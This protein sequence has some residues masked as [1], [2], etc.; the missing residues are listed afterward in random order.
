MHIPDGYLSPQTCLA[1]WGVMLPIWAKAANKVKQTL[2]VEQVPLLSMGAAFSFI[3]MMFNVPIPDGTTGH[4]VGGTL[5]A[6]ILGPWA[7]V[8][9]ISVALIMQALL[10]GDGGVL[11]IGANCFNIGVAL[12]FVGYY[13]YK[14]ISGNA[15]AGSTRQVVAAGVAAYIAINVAGLLTGLELG[16]QPLLFK[17]ADGT[18][19]YNPYSL[20][21]ALPAMALAHFTIAGM[22]EAIVTASVFMCLHKTEPGLLA[23]YSTSS[24]SKG[25]S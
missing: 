17:A 20:Y 23:L 1:M 11:A 14:L 8:I 5:L 21:Q 3:I 9:G 25:G 7:A 19:L 2:R 18:P 13:V 4:A 22:V 6:I 10:F 24:L 15:L 12:P 16:L